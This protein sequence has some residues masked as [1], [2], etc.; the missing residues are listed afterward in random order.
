MSFLGRR[1][2]APAFA[3][4]AVAEATFSRGSL[5]LAPD[6]AGVVIDSNFGSDERDVDRLARAMVDTIRF[7]E[8]NPLADLIS[9]VTFPR[10]P[11]DF[12]TL[13]GL[14]RKLCGSAYHPCGTVRMGPADDPMA[15]VDQYC[16]ARCVDR[17]VVADASIMPTVPRAN[18]NLTCI[19]IGES[20]GEWIRTAPSAYGL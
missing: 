16:R 1:S 2:G 11:A 6:G 17:L 3:I 12:D 5:R 19:M 15:V 7:T 14:V 10:L 9:A 13:K 4:A 8:T 20:V 18:T